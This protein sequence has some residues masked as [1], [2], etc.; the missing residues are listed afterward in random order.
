MRVAGVHEEVARNAKRI[1]S[2]RHRSRRGSI[3]SA[4]VPW[5]YVGQLHEALQAR[6]TAMGNASSLRLILDLHAELRS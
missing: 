1:A 4:W 5:R 2:S 6:L 3:R